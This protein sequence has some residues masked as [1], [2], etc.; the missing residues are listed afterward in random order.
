MDYVAVEKLKWRSRRSM[1][2]LDLYFERFIN[3]GNFAKLNEMELLAYQHLIT[4][5]DADLLL[6]F[7][8]KEELADPEL[9]NLV[10]KIAQQNFY[11]EMEHD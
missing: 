1:L 11:K 6:L 9:Q 5:D 2:E 8:G 4:L 7:Q 10:N 3:D